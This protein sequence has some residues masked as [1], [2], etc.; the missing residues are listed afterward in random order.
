MWES[1]WTKCNIL[2]DFAVT[3]F[4]EFENIKRNY[5]LQGLDKHTMNLNAKKV[6]NKRENCIFIVRFRKS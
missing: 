1:P 6:K 4:M 2:L 5:V 3:K